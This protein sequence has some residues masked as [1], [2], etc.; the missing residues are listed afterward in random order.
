MK[1]EIIAVGTE[2]LLGQIVNTNA[3]FLSQ[4]LALM[5]ID[6]YFQTV[7]GDNERRLKE[8]LQLASSRA[9]L[10][11]CTG[12]IGPTQD[13][14]TKDVLAAFLNRR[15]EMHEPSLAKITSFFESRGVHMVESNKRQALILEGSDP[16]INETGLAVGIGLSQGNNHYIVLPGP[17]SEMRP[18]FNNYAKQWLRGVMQEETPLR[19]RMLMFGGIGESMLEDRLLDLIQAQSDPTIASYAKEGEVAIRLTTRAATEEEANLKFEKVETEIRSRIGDHL[20]ADKAMSLEAA[21]LELLTARGATF[22]VAESCSGGRL[23]DLITAVP[24]S[25]A[26]FKGGLVCYTNEVKHRLLGVPM[27]VLEGADAPGAV[28]AETAELLA[29][30][31]L[32]A[33]G[34]DYAVSITG[35]AGPAS[36]EGKPVGLVYV[37][38]ADVQGRTHVKKVH[39]YGNRETIKLRSAKSALYLL[40]SMLKQT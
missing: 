17:P 36:S 16:L 38:Y 20:Y 2:L 21:V 3:Q 19:S 5:G 24:G 15:I 14:L 1:A 11:V 25:S 9:D 33:T 31:T 4:E 6:V 18:M 35:V 22:A 39:A 26:V 30:G 13:D 34:A 37:G 12:G 23:S 7:V 40:W 8:A 29:R 27:E 32:Q 28:S 10:V